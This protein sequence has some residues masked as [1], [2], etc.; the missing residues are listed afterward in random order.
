MAWGGRLPRSA[1]SIHLPRLYWPSGIQASPTS[2]T[3]SM[4]TSMQ[5]D[6]L[7]SS[8]SAA[9]AKATQSRESDLDWMI[10]VVTWHSSPGRLFIENAPSGSSLKT[11]LVSSRL[12]QDGISARSSQPLPDILPDLFSSPQKQ[13]GIQAESLSKPKT[14]TVLRGECW[15]HSTSE[16]THTLAPFHSDASVCSLSDILET[17]AVP[18]RYYL[19]AKACA[20]ILRRAEKRGRELPAL[21]R[22]A[23]E[24]VVQKSSNTLSSETT[25]D[26]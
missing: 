16:W 15:T 10:R 12:I 1:R 23:L 11:S 14:A 2:A 25:A 20:G 17:G 5:L 7:T 4:Q 22:Q 24:A 26:L 21:L 19:S 18:P 8:S 9:P 3:W 13:D 6:L